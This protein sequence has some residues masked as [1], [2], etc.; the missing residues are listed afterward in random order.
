MPRITAIPEPTVR[1]ADDSTLQMLGMLW[2]VDES[3]ERLSRKMLR[4]IGVT[5]P[6]RAVLLLVGRIEGATAKRLAQILRLHASTISGIVRRLEGD[7]YL[8]RTPHEQDGRSWVLELTDEGKRIVLVDSGTV[9]AGV[10]KALTG[11]SATDLEAGR[12]M[13][14]ALRRC[15][16][17]QMGDGEV[18]LEH[19]GW[20]EMLRS[21]TA[22]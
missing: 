1:V 12:R 9:E 16:E 6:Q 18:D 5:G 13:M 4:D 3:L 20:G 21:I 14:Q 11:L 22:S 8:R 15:I 10:R 2:A 7:G 19:D 17:E